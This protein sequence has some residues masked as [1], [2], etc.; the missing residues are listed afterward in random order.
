MS[1]F[2]TNPNGTNFSTDEL[3]AA[4]EV[5]QNKTHWK[6]EISAVI[7]AAMRA[8][9]TAAIPFFTATDATFQTIENNPN[10]LLV[11]AAGYW[12]GPAN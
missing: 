2:G 9:V 11:T 3:R 12:A 6:G 1:E 4:F 8:V 5:V 10:K 7:P